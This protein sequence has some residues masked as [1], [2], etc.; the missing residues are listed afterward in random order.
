MTRRSRAS[1]AMRGNQNRSQRP[2]PYDRS[3]V[4]YL[5]KKIEIQNNFPIN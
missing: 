3:N 2:T 5:S 1:R 4:R